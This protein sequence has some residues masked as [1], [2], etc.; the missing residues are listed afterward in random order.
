MDIVGGG[1]MHVYPPSEQLPHEPGPEENWQESFVLIWYDLKQSVGGFFRLGHEPN[2]GRSQFMTN[3]F[4]PEGIFH[5]S[6][7]LPLRPEDRR[8]NG[9][10]NGDGSLGYEYDGRNIVWTVR[11]PGIEARL[12]VDNWV[13]DINGFAP[14]DRAPGDR[15]HRDHV[16][17]ACGVRGTLTVKGRTYEVEAL[18]VRDHGWG[19]R[20]WGGYLS[21]RWLLGTFDRDNSF[22]AVTRLTGDSP[23]TRVG[24]VI[25]NGQAIYAEKIEVE[26]IILADAG[27]NRGG[28][29]RMTLETGERFEAKFEPLVPCLASWVH[30]IIC[31][32][33]MCRVRWG[34]RVGFGI[35]ETTA[36]LQAGTRRPEVLEPGTIWAEGWHP[37]VVRPV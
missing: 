1:K 35:F 2:A 3:I 5:R 36:N 16:D 28:N 12:V 32:D 20:A 25:R 22:L 17:A 6:S 30:G 7:T 13:P 34:D 18:A 29:L 14:R 33:S 23:I 24:W 10:S 19:P 37:G 15:F 27:T 21:H 31:F 8:D 9:L 26:A 11:E 4:A